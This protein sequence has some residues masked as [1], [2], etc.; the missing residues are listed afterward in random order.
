[1][2]QL[3]SAVLV[4]AF[5]FAPV[6]SAQT[7]QPAPVPTPSAPGPVA[8]SGP[9]APVQ[10][11][12]APASAGKAWLVMDYE[13]GQV[14]AGENIDTP[15]DPASITKVMTTYVVEAELAAGKI[16]KDDQVLISERAWREG[17]AG[18]DGSYSGF[19][20]N[21]HAT[22]EELL[23]GMIIQS[24]NDASIALAEHVAG[25]EEAFAELMNNYARR[26]GMSNSHF[27]NSHGLTAPGHQMSARDI[28]IL[29]RAL[30]HD[31]PQD[32]A[33]HAVKEYTH[34]N[35]RQYNRNGLLW[36]DNSVDGIKTGHTSAAGY[37]LL[38]SAKR[39]DQRLISVVMGIEGSRNEGFRLR[40]GDSLALLNWGF[41]FYETQTLYQ[42]DTR[43]ADQR[44]WKGTVETLPLGLTEPLRISFPRGRYDDLKASIDV[45][46]QLTAPIAKGQQLGV[47]RVSLDDETV[48]ERPLVALEE[49]PEAGFF[50]KLYDDFWLWWVSE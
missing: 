22:V 16:K 17:G 33:I 31:F 32:Y 2:K 26:L 7:P 41:R 47:V 27:V 11:P 25:T 49:I 44:V 23:H 21:S 43:I 8:S 38:A 50:G 29:G 36:K 15:L 6:A 19:D 5:A 35:I 40:E 14:L 4:T 12:D 45:P 42:G 24:G 34:N 30:I 1:M 3:L 28:A 39:G 37:C 18:T 48:A 9:A 46:T 13:S 10:I 20:V